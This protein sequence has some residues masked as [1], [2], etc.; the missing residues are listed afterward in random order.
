LCEL[1]PV[2]ALVFV[3]GA[4]VVFAVAALSVFVAA[5]VF[6]VVLAT[7]VVFR[8]AVAALDSVSVSL[9]GRDVLVVK[10]CSAQAKR[11]PF[12]RSRSQ[13]IAKSKKTFA[14]VTRLLAGLAAAPKALEQ[15][16]AQPA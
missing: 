16:P 13:P 11:I 2:V 10:G 8:V 3:F 4:A 5:V 12:A 14:S 7:A 15:L 6:E 9:L 1:G